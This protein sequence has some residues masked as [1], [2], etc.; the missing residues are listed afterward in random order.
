VDAD[1]D[2]EVEMIVR[3]PNMSVSIT[4]SFTKLNVRDFPSLLFRWH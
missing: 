4:K 2:T 1:G 3:V